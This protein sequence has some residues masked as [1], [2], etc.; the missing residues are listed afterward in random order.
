MSIT[1][2][3]LAVREVPVA[4]LALVALSSVGLR[5]TIALSGHQITLVVLGSDAV[6]VTSL[7]TVRRESVSSR[8]TFVALSANDVWLALAVTSMFLALLAERARWV[9]IAG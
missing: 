8:C 7:T 9:T 3:R 1:V 4:S 6:T 2:T 5:M